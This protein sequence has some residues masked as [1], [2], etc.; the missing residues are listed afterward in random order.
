ML[1]FTH[2]HT[3][4]HTHTHVDTHVHTLTH[5]TT[6]TPTGFLPQHS[7]S[8][9][10][11]WGQGRAQQRKAIK[12]FGDSVDKESLAFPSGVGP[13]TKGVCLVLPRT[14]PCRS[15]PSTTP[16]QPVNA[17]KTENAMFVVVPTRCVCVTVC[18][19]V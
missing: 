14:R 18:D 8:W 15:L 11:L 13:A 9:T 16:W 6:N 7:G 5:I 2:A 4:A 17:T 1:Q 10:P 12:V 19:C 3:R